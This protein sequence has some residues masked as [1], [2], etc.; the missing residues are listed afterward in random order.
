MDNQKSQHL[1][2]RL[3]HSRIIKIQVRLM[4]IKAMPV[5][6]FCNGIPRPVRCFEILENNSRILVFFR[7]V[8]PDIEILVGEII[9]VAGV[10]DPGRRGCRP[11]PTGVT[12]SGYS[13]S[14]PRFLEPRILIGGVIDHQLR[15]DTQITLMCSV[16][17]RAEIVERA[18]I[19]IHVEIIGDVVAVIAQRG[20]IERQHPDCS[21]SEL[22][23]IIQFF[24]QP[25]E[26]THP[27]AVA[28]VK[29]LD[30]QF[31]DDRV[32]VPERIDRCVIGSLCHAI[33]F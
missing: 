11:C 31:V 23:E 27:V 21:D 25:A 17:K 15:D 6:R 29:G 24:D 19:R 18:E 32:L 14:A 28:V 9:I 5:I 7:G 12:D 22:L 26:I 16:Q 10:G 3:M 33:N 8:A 4:G 20:R 1:L 30:V 13:Y 2:H